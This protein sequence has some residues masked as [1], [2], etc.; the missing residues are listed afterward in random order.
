V[1]KPFILMMSTPGSTRSM[2]WPHNSTKTY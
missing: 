2:A 1:I